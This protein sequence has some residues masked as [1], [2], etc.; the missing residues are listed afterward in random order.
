MIACREPN[1]GEVSLDALH[2]AHRSKQD[3]GIVA[4]RDGEEIIVVVAAC[5]LPERLAAMAAQ[6]VERSR[7]G[8]CPAL[9]FRETGAANKIRERCKGRLSS[10]LQ[11]VLEVLDRDAVQRAQADA[12]LQLAFDR[13]VYRRADNA[14]RTHH[15]AVAS[16][17]LNNRRRRIK[18][19][20]LVVEQTGCE[21]GKAMG[22]QPGTRIG[23]Q[24]KAQG[25]GL[26]ETI[27]RE[28]SE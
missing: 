14:G 7:T 24:C 1:Q 22:L 13:G 16:G 19:H 25:M 3:R 5:D 15:E 6:G 4:A 17:V 20:R 12:K 23:N 9:S 26:G 27:E 2:D 10:F 18:A 28:G 8:Q 21:L 11:H